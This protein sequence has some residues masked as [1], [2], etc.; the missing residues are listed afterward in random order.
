MMY[1][2]GSLPMSASKTRET[3]SWS[4]ARVEWWT[5]WA[6]GELLVVGASM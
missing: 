1:L 2:G 3:E 4:G 6:R 5:H